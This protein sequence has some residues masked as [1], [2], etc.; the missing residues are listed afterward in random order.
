MTEIEDLIEQ[1]KKV[2]V[3][4]ARWL[5]KCLVSPLV[6]DGCSADLS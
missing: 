1:I 4:R 3:I 5:N 2:R 6:L